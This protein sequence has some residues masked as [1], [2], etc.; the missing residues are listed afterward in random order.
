MGSQLISV[1][2]LVDALLVTGLWG[3]AMSVFAG[4]GRNRGDSMLTSMMLFQTSWTEC[5]QG[6][7]AFRDCLAELSGIFDA[8]IVR[9]LRICER[10]GRQ[11]T[12]A[13]LDRGAPQGERP[14]TLSLGPVLFAAARAPVRLGTVWTLNELDGAPRD[15]L[16][17]R[18][19]RWMGDR[20]I[21]QVAAIPLD[22]TDIELDAIELYFSKPLPDDLRANLEIVAATAMHAWRRRRKGRIARLLRATPAIAE[23]MAQPLMPAAISPLSSSNPFNLTAAEMRICGLLQGGHSSASVMGNLQISEPTL[24]THLRNIYAKTGTRGQVDLVRVLLGDPSSGI[25]PD[26]VSQSG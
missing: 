10:S 7:G 3:A 9:V 13:S 17:E 22:R 4:V 24:R 14:L 23:R 1:I 15:I 16:G 5:L 6:E 26:A 25:L 12:I 11:R 21:R 20:G 2:Q 18:A 8:R 19:L